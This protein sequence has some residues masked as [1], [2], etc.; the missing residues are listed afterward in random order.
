MQETNAIGT[1]WLRVDLLPEAGA[2]PDPRRLSRLSRRAPRLLQRPDPRPRESFRRAGPFGKTAEED[3][4][5]IGRRGEADFLA[6]RPD[7][8]SALSMK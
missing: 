4:D 3:L 2:A 7:A 8:S 6:C 5:G 1:A